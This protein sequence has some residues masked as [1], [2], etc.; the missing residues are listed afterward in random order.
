MNLSLLLDLAW[1]MVNYLLLKKLENAI[2]L[3][4]I[5]LLEKSKTN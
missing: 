4:L 2:K 1:L 5:K 3:A